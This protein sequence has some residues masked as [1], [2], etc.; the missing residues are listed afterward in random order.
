VATDGPTYQDCIPG[1]GNGFS[2]FRVVQVGGSGIHRDTGALSPGVKPPE[3]ETDHLSSPSVE[4]KKKYALPP[5][6]HTCYWC[7]D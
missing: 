3:R 7:G 5:L 2:V 4:V 1:K 6:S